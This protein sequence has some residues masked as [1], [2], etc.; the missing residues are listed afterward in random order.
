MLSTLSGA[1]HVYNY[2]ICSGEPASVAVSVVS[3]T[4]ASDVVAGSTEGVV[5]GEMVGS[6]GG[7]DS[8][9]R[10]NKSSSPV[11]GGG[12]NGTKGA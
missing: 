9:A 5:V 10:V 3:A 12:A 1:R 6:V 7:G 4:G 2:R 11:A 8:T